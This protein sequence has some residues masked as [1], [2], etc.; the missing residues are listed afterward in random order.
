MTEE[1]NEPELEVVPTQEGQDAAAKALQAIRNRSFSGRHPELGKMKNCQLCYL[2]HRE[3]DNPCVQKF[4]TGRYD[5]RDT[6]P[7]LI[8]G[9]T[10]ETAPA[11]Y[12]TKVKILLGR[13]VFNKRRHFPHHNYRTLQFLELVRT[14]L[15]DEYTQEDLVRVRAKAKRVLA[16]KFGRHGFLPPVWQKEKR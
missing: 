13:A 10:P 1:L 15:P 16:E 2:R 11:F 7:L 12:H 4:A 5:M 9:E 8:A 6:K 14:L 3:N